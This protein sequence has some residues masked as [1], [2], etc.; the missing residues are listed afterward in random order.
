MHTKGR[1]TREKAPVG[2]TLALSDPPSK[3]L[4]PSLPDTISI[5]FQ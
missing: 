3:I 1:N 2:G 4:E 5:L